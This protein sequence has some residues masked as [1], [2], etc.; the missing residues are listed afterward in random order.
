MCHFKNYWIEWV[1]LST[2]CILHNVC[3]CICQMCFHRMKNDNDCDDDDDDDVIYQIETWS[4]FYIDPT[5]CLILDHLTIGNIFLN[6][7]LPAGLT[8]RAVQCITELSFAWN[9]QSLH[10]NWRLPVSS[11]YT[12]PLGFGVRWNLQGKHA[13]AIIQLKIRRF[14]SKSVP[15]TFEFADCI[16]SSVLFL[17]DRNSVQSLEDFLQQSENIPCG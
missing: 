17:G 2:Q 10:T 8:W 5:V 15:L 1:I 13:N 9:K 4:F 11:T 14:Y 16:L 7:C 12:R 3:S 6:N